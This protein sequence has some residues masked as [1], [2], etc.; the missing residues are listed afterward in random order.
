[1]SRLYFPGDAVTHSFVTS[2]AT[3]VAAN[4]DS[5]PT[6]SVY[7]NGVLD[8][9]VTV[10]ITNT[11]TG[12]YLA[13]YTV[14]TTYAYGD[15]VECVVSATIGGIATLAVVDSLRLWK[16]ALAT[17][18]SVQASPTPTTTAFAGSSALASSNGFYNKQ[19]LV[20][21]TGVNAR[22]AKEI[23]GYVGSTRTFTTAAFPVAPSAGD[24]FAVIGQ[25]P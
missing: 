24:A 15:V 14:P 4:A 23:S 22:Q 2:G 21:L 1:M 12:L 17:T 13:A 19:W 9:T 25:G 10:T 6:A 3:G 8:G 16:P 7:R 5:L 20:F 18:D 11:T